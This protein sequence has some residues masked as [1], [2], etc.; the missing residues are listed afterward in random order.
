MTE[1]LLTLD[2]I[3][4][5]LQSEAGWVQAIDDLCLTIGR[6]QTFALVGESGCGKSMT[7]LS[8]A[9]LLPDC[10]AVIAGSAHL[11]DQQNSNQNSNPDS[12]DLL[13]LP[14][15]L[16]R[17]IRGRRVS[18]IFQEPGT[19]L[20]P[21][22]TVG[23][24]LL[25]VM[26]THQSISKTE[27]Q[28]RAIRWLERVGLKDAEKRLAQYPF[29][30]SG[31]Q[32]QRVMIAVALA[33]EPDLLI[34]DEPTTALDVSIQAQ[35]LSLLQDLQRE[36]GMAIL[37]ITHDLGIVSQMADHVA[38]M[39]AGQV[40]ESAPAAAFFAH[41][42]HPYAQALLGALPEAGTR[43]CALK[44]LPG[45]VPSLVSPPRG[46]RFASRC[47][48]VQAACREQSPDLSDVAQ[49]HAVRCYFPVEAGAS[50]AANSAT[51]TVAQSDRDGSSDSSG[52]SSTLLSVKSLSVAYR[53][54]GS[55]LKT[56]FTPVVHEVSFSLQTGKTLALVGESG[57]G[58]STIARAILRLLDGQARV[59]GSAH[60]GSD[61]VLQTHG[62]ALRHLRRHMQVVFQDPF[63]SL[64]PRQR[65]CDI[66]TE[67]VAQLCP[68]VSPEEALSRAQSVLAEVGLPPE[69]FNRFPHE[70]SGG[71]RQ[72]IAIARALVVSPD[73]LILD[74]PTSALDV[75]VQAQVLNLLRELQRSRG[76]AFLLITH[77]LAVVEY[78]A[79][80][81]IVLQ[82][83]K[84]VE[85]GDVHSVMSSP[86]T[87]YT[88]ML[89]DAVPRVQR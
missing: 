5:R 22:L 31:G 75:S 66:L 26:L 45:Q 20:N 88:R 81:V 30:L 15:Q 24:Q 36:R 13:Q 18:M 6:G 44:A 12:T 17:T 61:D 76:V 55:L 86:R 60:L 77:N 51:A 53:G 4:T 8:V 33:A 70:F 50:T 7:A 35:V 11:S 46:C 73:L 56:A 16:M 10:G 48:R 67:G 23:E 43:G 34:A 38:L 72:R 82:G 83:G 68:G 52:T 14:E 57:S 62:S 47:D 19:S 78:M 58:K 87:D 9:R 1:A 25:E 21:V 54:A 40:V 85:A 69:S 80:D 79:D 84:I 32:K 37:I 39:Y 89:I 2:G 3:S 71:Q 49:A 59:S 27:A 41:P 29:Q 42:R 28:A 64:N 65:V 74:E 63:S